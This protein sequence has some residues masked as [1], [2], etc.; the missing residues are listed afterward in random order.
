MKASTS[1]KVCYL[2]AYMVVPVTKS[3][4]QQAGSACRIYVLNLLHIIII[5]IVII[6]WDRVCTSLYLYKSYKN[7][8]RLYRYN[9][10]TV[11]A[12][13]LTIF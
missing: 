13:D 4:M 5:I 12:V 9:F 7:D 11:N 2:H 3:C 10:G 8:S 6:I 1:R